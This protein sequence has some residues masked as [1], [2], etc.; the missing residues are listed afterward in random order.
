MS[1][2]ITY[3]LSLTREVYHQ[4]RYPF[5]THAGLG[6]RRCIKVK[7]KVY[8]LGRLKGAEAWSAMCHVMKNAGEVIG[9]LMFNINNGLV[10]QEMCLYVM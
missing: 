1:S 8:S 4:V 9:I 5:H 3:I 7:M 6:F 2:K 10:K